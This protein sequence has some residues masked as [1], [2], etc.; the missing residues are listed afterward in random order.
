MRHNVLA[1]K[2]LLKKNFDLMHRKNSKVNQ[3]KERVNP[4]LL[5]VAGQKLK[6]DIDLFHGSPSGSGKAR[7]ARRMHANS[8]QSESEDNPMKI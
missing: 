4:Y 7:S 1:N 8:A 6:G 5:P 3:S 2:E